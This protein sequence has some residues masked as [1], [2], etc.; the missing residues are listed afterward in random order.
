MIFPEF[1]FE[2][3]SKGEEYFW[4]KMKRILPKN[5]VSF[6]NYD[7]DTQEVDVILLV[8][9]SGILIIEIKGF[10]PQNIQEALDNKH[11]L[12]TDGSLENSPYKQAKRYRSKYIKKIAETELRLSKKIVAI[13]ACYPYFS[14]DDIISK[15]LNRICDEELIISAEDLENWNQFANRINT[16]FKMTNEVSIV[17]AEYNHLDYDELVQIANIISPSCLKKSDL[18]E[19]VQ[20]DNRENDSTVADR[21]YSLLIVNNSETYEKTVLDQMVEKWKQGTKVWFFSSNK[22]ACDYL[23]ETTEKYIEEIAEVDHLINGG[24]IFNCTI[25]YNKKIRYS[26]TIKNGEDVDR[27]HDQLMEIGGLVAFNAEQYLVEHCDSEDLVIKAGAG[28]GK[29]FLL[30]SRLAYL[31]WR[32]QYTK[33]DLLRKIILITFTNDATNEM[34]SR[35]EAYFKRMF[36]L[37]YNVQ[38]FQYIESVEN[39]MISTIDSFSKRIINYYS[40]YL[41]LGINSSVTSGTL[42]KSTY[43]RDAI[44]EE[45]AK[46]EL[47]EASYVLEKFL[48]DIIEKLSNRSCD[49]NYLLPIFEGNCKNEPKLGSLVSRVP[50]I[51]MQIQ[52]DCE[53]DNKILMNHIIIYLNRIVA[54]FNNGTIERNPSLQIDYVFI[55]EFQDTDD[56]QIKIIADLKKIFGFKL[57]VVGDPKQ[58]IY[59]F[60]G[61]TDD[62]AF[63]VL[64]N[65]LGYTIKTYSLVKNYRTNVQLLNYMDSVFKRLNNKRGLLKYSESDYLVGVRNPEIPAEVIKYQI[66]SDDDREEVI[67]STIKSFIESTGSDEDLA[68]LVRNNSQVAKIKDICEK[69]SISYVDIDTGGK[70][71]QSDAVIDLYKLI[72]ALINNQDAGYLYNL[73]TTCYC[74]ESLNKYKVM[75]TN[76]VQLFYD[77]LPESL[78]KWKIYIQKLNDE[79]VLKVL[80]TIY[81]DVCPWYIY[82]QKNSGDEYAKNIAS[83]RYRN[84]FDKIFE[85]L[86][87]NTDGMHLTINSIEEFLNV[88][89]TTMQ[90]EEEPALE[91]SFRI[92]CRTI[93]RAKGKEYSYVFVPFGDTRIDKEKY[94]GQSNFIISNDKIGYSLKLKDTEDIIENETY[95]EVLSEDLKNQSFEEARIMYVAITRAKK[96]IMYIANHKYTT[97]KNGV[98]W[99]QMLEE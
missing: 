5:Y 79:P 95:K 86:I 23:K 64:N 19:S 48:S 91:S 80:R 46:G 41:G 92:Q 87:N 67:V 16:I 26:F 50:G 35:I 18:V 71:Y 21:E 49:P 4:S 1:G 37:T 8:P 65:E 58:S 12:K 29:T 52:K 68:I 94:N 76:A 43:I 25:E 13:A 78:S 85:I 55:D 6:H 59:R 70:L 89:I 45:A 3:N 72:Q 39:M 84:D 96:G 24:S 88:M 57:F 66:E 32:H 28:T 81:D 42:V 34:R 54:L 2:G 53:N 77:E 51:M 27:Y 98:V 11:I 93:H 31:C 75:N 97:S 63:S 14:R 40:Y 56:T 47:V 60:R 69:N 38:Y 36:I 10:Y 17:D 82:E 20:Q 33:E 99:Q 30:V 7:L 62:K 15:H 90:E 83:L 9:D 22:D 61:A 44:N 74:N 73:Y